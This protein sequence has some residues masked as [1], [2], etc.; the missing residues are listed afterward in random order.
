MKRTITVSKGIK[1]TGYGLLLIVLSITV[2]SYYYYLSVPSTTFER[3]KHEQYDAIIVPG[4]P[5]DANN[6]S[7]FLK[8][9]IHWS[10]FLYKQGVAKNIIYSGN[11]VHT[12]YTEAN[13]M[14]KFGEK[15]GI[16]SSNIFAEDKAEHSTE[17]LYYSYLLAKKLGFKK[18]ALATDPFQSDMLDDFIEKYDMDIDLIPIVYGIA[19]TINMVQPEI[20]FKSEFIENFVPLSEREDLSERMSG[21]RGEKIDWSKIKN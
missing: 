20:D 2:H 12:A 3:V 18:L 21:T 9:R 6:W 8:W 19:D 16:P 5:Y 14:K 10:A 7:V 11:A 4:V 15:L 1:Y 17:N 13:I